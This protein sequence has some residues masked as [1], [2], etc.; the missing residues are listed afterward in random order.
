M[1][2]RSESEIDH[3]LE[4]FATGSLPRYCWTHAAHIAMAAAKLY[5]TDDEGTL[6]SI[7][8]GI[9]NYNA[10]QGT[11]NT[12]TSGYHETL[13]VFWV[14]EVRRYL[15]GAKPANRLEAVRGAIQTL[16]RDSGLPRRQYSF[17]VFQS[18]DAR[19][20]WIP[21]DIG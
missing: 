13:T 12:A 10:S 16:G 19:A 2:F 14:N 9:L 20:R 11:A 7:R 18:A 1:D 15:A 3:F 8:Q 6:D 4:G 21:P 17:D 5:R